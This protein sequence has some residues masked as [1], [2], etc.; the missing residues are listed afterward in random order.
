MTEPSSK[1]KKIKNCNACCEP[2]PADAS[3]CPVC[4]TTLQKTPLAKLKDTAKWF[5]GALTLSSLVLG[6]ISLNNIYSNWSAQ[7]DEIQE[8]VSAADLLTTTGNYREAWQLL[9]RARK[10]NPSGTNVQKSQANLSMVWSR[11]MG[12]LKGEKY[13]QFVDPMVPV[14]AR[15]LMH[16]S[17][18]KA[19]TIK[20][21]LSWIRY[22]Q[23][24]DRELQQPDADTI[25][26]VYKL[27]SDAIKDDKN[28]VWANALLAYVIVDAD[29][30]IK[31]AE[32]HLDFVIQA[33]AKK[34]GRNSAQYNWMRKF[35]WRA[36]T[37]RL[38]GRDSGDDKRLAQKKEYLRVTN[39][40]RLNNEE[41]PDK[42]FENLIYG[43]YGN[44]ITGFMVDELFD[45]LPPREHLQTFEWLFDKTQYQQDK[46]QANN[47]NYVYARLLE[48]SGQTRQALTLYSDLANQNVREKFDKLVD[49]GIERITGRKTERELARLARRYSND[50]IPE[51]ADL[52]KFHAD[53]LLNFDPQWESKNLQAALEFFNNTRRQEIL[54]R[55]EETYQ[56]LNKARDR[57]KDWLEIKNEQVKNYGYLSSYSK[58]S[59]DI[60]YGNYYAIWDLLG[61]Y[62]L[63]TRH[64]DAAIA[65]WSE[66]SKRMKPVPPSIFLNLT[67]AYNVRADHS[68][69]SK[70][71]KSAL[72][73]LKKYV[74]TKV[75]YGGALNFENVK[76]EPLLASLRKNA[77]YSRIMRGR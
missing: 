36:L 71:K 65:E 49:A 61:Q 20:A 21:H 46:Y 50:N 33:L 9:D 6:V 8:I 62:A 23:E 67:K 56:M 32:Q 68:N 53:T 37:Q 55:Q 63:V 28:N 43:N 34:Y 38:A 30:D 16:A 74:T 13:S 26:V 72:V 76:N 35:Q 77:A 73:N 59:E 14:L 57:I 47:F 12:L 2:I 22:L 19:A 18:E 70:D 51:N 42:K 31:K 15:E 54:A 29:S 27:F 60:A 52:W 7:F 4:H 17:A 75:R 24:K 69:N 58:V 41:H 44:S 25:N 66:V 39:D 45:A 1:L 48:M 64:L 40:M 11:N 5:A 10:I 3:V